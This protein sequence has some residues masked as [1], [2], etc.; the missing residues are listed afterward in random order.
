MT[1]KEIL[2]KMEHNRLHQAD[3]LE[4]FHC[5]IDVRISVLAQKA[6]LIITKQQN[7]KI[8]MFS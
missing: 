3:G 6:D 4:K 1:K 7:T 5:Q 2:M 8:K